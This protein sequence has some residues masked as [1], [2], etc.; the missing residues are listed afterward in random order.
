MTTTVPYDAT[1]AI[2]DDADYV[3]PLQEGDIV[4]CG[5]I[6]DDCKVLGAWSDWVWLYSL[7]SGSLAPFTARVRDCDLMKQAEA[8]RWP[9]R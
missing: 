8:P 4:R 9:Y 1:A 5:D 6:R 7:N 3:R 2:Y